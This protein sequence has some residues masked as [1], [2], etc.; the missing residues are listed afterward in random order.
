MRNNPIFDR[1]FGLDL[2]HPFGNPF[3][4]EQCMKDKVGYEKLDDEIFEVVKGDVKTTIVCKF[5]KEGYLV[6]Y[7][8]L[9]ELISDSQI[10]KTLKEDLHEAIDKEDYERATEVQKKINKIRDLE[11]QRKPTL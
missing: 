11:D 5:N 10:L 6:S 9:S 8:S 2:I 7:S 3:K 1:L 4:L